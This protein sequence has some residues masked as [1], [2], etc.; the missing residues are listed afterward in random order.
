MESFMVFKLNLD[1]YST[2]KNRH[3]NFFEGLKNLNYFLT[4]FVM[5]SISKCYY[6]F[7]ITDLLSI[8][9]IIPA[10]YYYFS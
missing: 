8:I 1:S 10:Q 4:E 5:N 9:T 7:A 3:L 6:S 2:I